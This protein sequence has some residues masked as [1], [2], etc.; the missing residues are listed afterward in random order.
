MK[1]K[2]AVY[3]NVSGSIGGLTYAHN[4]GGMYARA[5]S[6]PVNTMTARRTAVRAN[7]A[8]ASTYWRN[9]LTAAQRGDWTAYAE[10]SP[11]T[12][13]F[14]DEKILTG[15]Q[16]FIRTH[17]LRLQAGEA[18]I[19][20]APSTPGFGV[21]V[22]EF[23]NTDISVATPGGTLDIDGS[24]ASGA[25]DAGDVL[26]YVGTMLSAGRNFYNGPWQFVDSVAI[27]A[28]ATTFNLAASYAPLGE[29]DRTPVDTDR[30]AFRALVVLDDGRVSNVYDSIETITDSSP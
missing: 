21:P 25:P 19:A 17:T 6:T 1:F 4:R 26:V 13:Q 20:A 12:D 8:A 2:S 28:S 14:G 11:V 23:T 16:M 5:R 18:A 29:S 10:A 7:F 3:T 24:L 30:Y 15:Q 22:S 9:T 27:A